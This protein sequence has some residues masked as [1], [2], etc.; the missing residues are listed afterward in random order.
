MIFYNSE[1]EMPNLYELKNAP[2]YQLVATI[3]AGY[4]CKKSTALKFHACL[5]YFLA[6]YG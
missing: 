5:S 4:H 1:A 6:F 3:A 2:I